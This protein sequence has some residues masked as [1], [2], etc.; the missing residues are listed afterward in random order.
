[1]KRFLASAAS[2]AVGSS[3]ALGAVAAPPDYTL[4]GDAEVV[5]DAVQ[6]RSDDDPGYGGVDFAVEEGTTFADLTELSTE[7]NVTDDGCAGGSPRYQVNLD[8]DGDGMTDGNVFIYLG[9]SPSFSG[10]PLN[11]WQD[12][13][14]LIG[15]NDACRYDTAQLIAGTQ[16][17]TYAGTL[18]ALGDAE[19]TGIQLVVD[20]GWAFPDGEQ[21]VLVRNAQVNDDT[22]FVGPPENKEACKNG[23]YKNFDLPTTFKNQGQCVSSVQNNSKNR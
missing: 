3:M 19:V 6:L 23:G 7:Y 13:G 10:C 17:N 18:A 5:G 1:M 2:I 12:S 4:F 21:T 11:T 8:D 15:N 22:A 16:C 14:N 20:A 9:P